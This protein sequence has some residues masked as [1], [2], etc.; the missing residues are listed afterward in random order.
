M[1]HCNAV[2]CD[3]CSNHATQRAQ[4]VVTA[5]RHT[6][7]SVQPG[8]PAS[9]WTIGDHAVRLAISHVSGTLSASTDH[10]SASSHHSV[11]LLPC[12]RV[13][14]AGTIISK[15]SL[16]ARLSQPEMFIF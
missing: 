2:C 5:E 9:Q 3:V 7:V 8:R 14:A 12:Q 10:S 11:D 15:K 1:L 16:A 4:C 13:W 6:A